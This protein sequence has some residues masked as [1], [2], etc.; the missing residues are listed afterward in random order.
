MRE[1][2]YGPSQTDTMPKQQNQV[3]EVF[4][5]YSGLRPDPIKHVPR[6]RKGVERDGWETP[7][8][9]NLEQKVRS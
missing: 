3:L 1:L 5:R 4:L 9:T 2:K 7:Y 6:G 8:R